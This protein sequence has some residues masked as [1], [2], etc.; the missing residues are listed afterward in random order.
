MLTQLVLPRVHVSVH[1]GERNGQSIINLATEI[2]G[3]VC[4]CV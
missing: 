2:L 4:V 1:L 3:L